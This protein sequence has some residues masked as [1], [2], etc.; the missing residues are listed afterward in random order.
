MNKN[1]WWLVGTLGAAIIVVIPKLITHANKPQGTA[2][3][4]KLLIITL[5]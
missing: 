5:L 2:K 4:L 1:Y 3:K